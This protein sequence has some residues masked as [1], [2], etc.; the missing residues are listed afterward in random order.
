MI[1]DLT[2]PPKINLYEKWAIQFIQDH[3][4]KNKFISGTTWCAYQGEC[5]DIE[6][7]AGTP[8]QTL[9]AF[10]NSPREVLENLAEI[11]NYPTLKQAPRKQN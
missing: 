7:K 2:S 1:S 8:D 3:K 5:E 11:L 9:F 4:V 10:G 6:A